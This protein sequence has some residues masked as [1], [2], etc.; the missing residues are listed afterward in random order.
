MRTFPA[1]IF[2]AALLLSGCGGEDAENQAVEE[3]PT[4]VKAIKF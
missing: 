1:I 4:A 2:A 3:Y